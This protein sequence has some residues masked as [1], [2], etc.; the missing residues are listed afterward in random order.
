MARKKKD[1]LEGVSE[2]LESLKQSSTL[3]RNLEEAQIWQRWPELAGMDF[4]AHGRPLG[5]RDGMLIIEVDSAVWMHKFAYTKRRL[6]RRINQA[7]G[8]DLVTEIYLTLT[9]DEKLRDPQD[10]A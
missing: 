6:M 2:I 9:E 8:R 7:I 1:G 5:V 3:G 10:R 4:M